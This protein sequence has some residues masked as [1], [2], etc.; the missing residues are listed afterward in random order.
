MRS[1]ISSALLLSTLAFVVLPSRGRAQESRSPTLFTTEHSLDLE[2]ISNPQIAP[3]GRQIIY[4]RGWVNQL[5]DKWENISPPLF[6]GEVPFEEGM[7]RVQE[8]CQAIMDKGR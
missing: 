5:E 6:Y 1:R 7:K 2:R 3:D 4:T 8:Q